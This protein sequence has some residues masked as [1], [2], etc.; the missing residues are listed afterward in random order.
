MMRIPVFCITLVAALGFA[1][2]TSATT[3]DIP[4]NSSTDD[5][6]ERPNGRVSLTS[7]DLEL[8]REKRNDQT[9]GVRFNRINIPPG[10]TV[11]NAYIQ[12]T[13]DETDSV[14]TTLLIE[15]EANDNAAKFRK[16]QYDIS[17]RPTT[18]ANVGWAPGPW[19]RAGDAGPAQRTPDIT[20]IVQEIVDRPGWAAGNSLAFVITGTG[21]RV[22]ESYNGSAIAAPRLHIEYGGG[23]GNLAPE[24]DA[25]P[26]A[27]LVI[28]SDT[29]VVDAAVSDDGLPAGILNTVW[30]HV[31]GTGSG[32]VTFGDP[33]A[34]TTTA[35]FTPPDPGTYRLRINADD[36]ELSAFDEL[37][38]TLSENIQVAAITQVNF[39]ATGFD[40]TTDTPLTVPAIDPAGLVYHAPTQR[41]FIADSEI[42]EVPA[43]FDIVQANLFETSPTVDML[44]DQW[45]LTQRTGN[46]P[47]LNREPTGI[48]FCAGDDHFYVSNDDTDRVYRYAYDGRSF[49]A[50][51]AVSTRPYSNDPEGITCD[52]DSGRIYVIGGVDIN[53]L[54][55]E[56]SEGFV[57]R[58]VLD[59]PATAGTSAGIP[60]D[61]E[62]I[63]YD[64][65]SG[66]VFV[67]S[68]PDRTLY[69]YATSGLFIQK[70]NI[71]GFTPRPRKPQGIS[72]GASS[73][74]PGTMS[75]YIAD[76][77][78]DNDHDPAERDGFIY[79]AE[80]QRAE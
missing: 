19:S 40:T 59:L 30:T 53:I 23:T 52:P 51:D 7:S 15:G 64:P 41:L 2:S 54:V 70:F 29:V 45:D 36:G 34:V 12:F 49:T 63:T 68:A 9:V 18:D 27:T 79:E 50:V 74:N 62:G 42:N 55:Y 67:M 24:V 16:I 57:L 11:M 77:G 60:D 48:A 39:V 47:A 80:I 21:T 3:L 33:S 13:V 14:A 71:E 37:L 66:H 22:A 72:I 10:S 58:D 1:V 5:A 69:E 32:T 61:P 6:E 65:V 46:E 56:Y 17:G 25:G 35:T 20:T 75:F 28:P 38:I 73:S 26:D 76:G 44:F 8:I 31:G 43:A 78:V 4:V